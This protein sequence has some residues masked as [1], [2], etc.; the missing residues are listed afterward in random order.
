MK[1]VGKTN[2]PFCGNHCCPYH[3]G[4]GKKNKRIIKQ[5]M[6]AKEKMRWKNED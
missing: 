3:Q 4:S 6:K 2:K 1:M 5:I